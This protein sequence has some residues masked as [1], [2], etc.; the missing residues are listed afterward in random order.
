MKTNRFSLLFV[1][2]L[3]AAMAV[4]GRAQNAELDRIV[5][6]LQAKYNK[7]SSFAADFTQLH[8]AAGGRQRR[9][10]GRML[11]KKPGRMRWDYA[12]PETKLFL[13]DG[14]WIYE[15]VPAEKFATRTSVKES[16]DMRAPFAFLLGRGNLRRD[17]KTIE[18]SAESPARAGN[19]VLRMIPK[20]AAGFRELLIEIDPATLQLA[21]LTLIESGGARSDFLF[22]NIRENG[23][24]PESQ[25]VFVP[26]AGVELRK[27]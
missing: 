7:L 1:F 23:A 4:A 17:F 20:R 19:R 2:P 16:D 26:P 22:S 6:G 10:T 5:S 11:L 8:N 25:F 9:E 27:N 15:Y 21:R 24:A 13:C 18:F 3:L 12:S 14:K